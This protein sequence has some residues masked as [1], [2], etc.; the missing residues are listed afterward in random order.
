MDRQINARVS[1]KRISIRPYARLPQPRQEDLGTRA[2]PRDSVASNT[3]AAAIPLVEVAAQQ[4]L[5]LDEAAG[6]RATFFLFY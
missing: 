2:P 3:T 4:P 5:V 6:S 1:R